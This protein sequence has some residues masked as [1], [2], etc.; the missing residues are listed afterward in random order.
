[1]SQRA[2]AFATLL[3][4]WVS[5]PPLPPL[6]PAGAPGRPCPGRRGRRRGSGWPGPLPPSRSWSWRSVP[7]GRPAFGRL[8]GPCAS[9]CHKIAGA[10][11]QCF[12]ALRETR[13]DRECRNTR[14]S[15]PG[16]VASWHPMPMVCVCAARTPLVLTSVHAFIW[17]FS[18]TARRPCSGRA[19]YAPQTPVNHINGARSSG[20]LVRLDMAWT[21]CERRSDHSSAERMICA[22]PLDQRPVRLEPRGLGR[23]CPLSPNERRFVLDSHGL[24]VVRWGETE[25]A[26]IEVQFCFARPADVLRHAKPVLLS[27]V[28]DIGEG[29]SLFR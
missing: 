21:T 15:A 13:C 14:T 10:L 9:L 25:H 20:F 29:D 8:G 16:V 24:E 28:G 2:R 1:L 11:Q 19:L 4:F 27:L 22:A 26:T 6:R 23:W 5:F 7:S 12:P 3:S 17:P 18:R